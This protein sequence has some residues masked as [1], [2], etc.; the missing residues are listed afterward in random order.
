[1]ITRIGSKPKS[2]NGL[3]Y[4]S[5]EH[6]WVLYRLNASAG[7]WVSLKLVHR[8]PIEGAANYWLGWNTKSKRLAGTRDAARLATSRPEEH[9]MVQKAM[10]D[11][12]PHLT[13]L[14]MAE[15]LAGEWDHVRHKR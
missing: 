3:I 4:S 12:Y 8:E 11:V 7:D 5:D 9:A 2:A 14:D 6:D 10:T 1:M 15:A 13:D